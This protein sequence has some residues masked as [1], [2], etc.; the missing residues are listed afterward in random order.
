MNAEEFKT[1]IAAVDLTAEDAR[2]QILKLNEGL[3]NSNTTLLSEYKT[4]VTAANET[5]EISRQQA[6][7]AEEDRLKLAGDFEGFKKLHEEEKNTLLAKANQLT[8]SARNALTERDKGAVKSAILSSVDDRYK[9]F[10]E[11]QLNSIVD[12]SYDETG[13]AITSIKDGDAQYASPTD[14]LNGVRESETWKHVLKATSLSGAG[15]KQS[16]NG[17]NSHSVNKKYSEMTLQEQIA[18]NT[19]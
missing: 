10:V 13:K 6:V 18:F 17:G 5:A 16:T 4:K 1:A 15:T 8:E 12:I 9:S 11:T 7:K 19:K 3:M 14:F 2:D